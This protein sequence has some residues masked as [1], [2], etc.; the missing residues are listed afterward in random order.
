M[1]TPLSTEQLIKKLQQQ[2]KNLQTQLEEINKVPDVDEHIQVKIQKTQAHF[3]RIKNPDGPDTGIGNFLLDIDITAKKEALYVPIS[4]ASGKK[5]TGFIYQIEGTGES[6]IVKAG[7][8]VKGQ[9]TSQIKLGTISY[10]AIPAGKTA[11]FRIQNEIKGQIGR[12]YKIVISQV[13]Y[14]S[15]PSDARYQKLVKEISSKNLQFK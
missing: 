2:V 12:S 7:I 1:S 4:V 13:S 6:S 11:T 15:K 14:K 10:C 3:Q 9:G 5:T 8:S